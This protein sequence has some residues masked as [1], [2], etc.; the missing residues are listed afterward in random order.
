M[1]SNRQQAIHR[2]R[3]A[4]TQG[5]VVVDE[6]V[7]GTT[8]QNTSS[9]PSREVVAILQPRNTEEVQSLVEVANEY[10]I[11]LY[12]YSTG[13]NWGLGSKLPTADGCALVDL[14]HLK[15]IRTVN[16]KHHYAVIEAGVTQEELSQYLRQN[17]LPLMLNVTGSTPASSVV[18][19]LLER[20]T[21]FFYHR[22]EDCRGIEVVLGSGKRLRTG[23]W[24]DGN[25]DIN[26]HHYKYGFGPYLDG[27][28]TQSNMGI[29]TAVVVD[30]IPKPEKLDL[31]LFTCDNERVPQVV[32]AVAKLHKDGLLHAIGHMFNDRRMNAILEEQMSLEWTGMAP[33]TGNAALVAFVSEQ[34]RTALTPLCNT[35]M[36]IS[37]EMA[38]ADGADPVVQGLYK[39][40]TG[41]PVTTFMEGMYNS[42]GG[43]VSVANLDDMDTS[44]YGM[45]AFLPILPADAGVVDNYLRWVDDIAKEYGVVPAVTLNPIDSNCLESVVN[46]YFDR[47]DAA[48]VERAHR[49]NAAFHQRLYERGVRF[50]RADIVNMRYIIDRQSPY[51]DTVEALSRAVDPNRIISPGRYNRP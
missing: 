31:L 34:I 2:F 9:F 39:L 10:K 24:D 19:N 22:T 29:V 13:R 26:H 45:L 40:H 42:V 14:G 4:L 47:T 35:L 1:T 25:E 28:F 49:A 8:I 44:K 21:G 50:Y 48:A 37:E 51:W 36:F 11:P 17:N 3:E 43:K 16:V 33:I 18:G 12:P 30:L 46:I 41:V 15:Q 27:L 7:I 20:G 32:E 5:T 38:L 6:D 23:Y